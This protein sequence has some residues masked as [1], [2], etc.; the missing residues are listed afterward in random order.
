MSGTVVLCGSLGSTAAMWDPQGPVLA[1]RRVVRVEHPGHGTAP[2]TE[3]GGIGDLARRVLDAAG[4][5]PFAF[6]GL[7][8]GGSI[9]TRLAVDAPE[10]ITSLVLAC[11]SQRFGEPAQWHER[12]AAVRS[13]GLEAIV[14]AVM[15]RWFTPAF[16]D[17]APFREMFLSVDPEGYARCCEAIA[18]FDAAPLLGRIR[19]PTLVVAGDRDPTSPPDHG[20]ALAD[21]IAGARLEVLDG[22]AH[23][24]SVERADAFN[25][26]LEEHL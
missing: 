12:A 24:A 7:S 8:L 6:V 25:T 26:L 22:A 11:T 4:D 23:L 20:R 14:D 5:G 3:V 9:G 10:R 1:G 21:G 19:V 17:T 16:P 15:G 13:Q 18:G 2:V